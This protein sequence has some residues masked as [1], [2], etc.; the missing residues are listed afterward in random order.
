M[1]ESKEELKSILM[2][3]KEKSEKAGLKLNI[4]KNQRSWHLI[5]PFHGK[6]MREK[7]KQWQTLFSWSPNHCRWWQ[8]WNKR[9]FLLGIK[10]M[11]NP[12]SVLKGSDI[13][14]LRKL[15]TVKTMIFPVVMYRYKSWTIK[16]AQCKMIDAFELCCW[17]RLLRV[18]WTGKR[19]NQSIPKEI[20]P[21]YSLKDWC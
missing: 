6:E 14:F 5:P 13:T 15:C 20:N 12:D 19:S 8:P 3:V 7:W 16:K 17:R 2:K 9:C 10:A 4:F 1:A 18:R 11:T 21:E